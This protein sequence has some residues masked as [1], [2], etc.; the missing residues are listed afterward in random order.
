METQ[1]YDGTEAHPSGVK[2][3]TAWRS[4]YGGRKS[5]WALSHSPAVDR[6]LRNAY[7]AERGLVSLG[8]RW[9]EKHFPEIVAPAQ[10]SLALG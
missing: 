1:T 8:D 6:G 4:I 10:L 5:L 2:A 3:K 9:R 7:F